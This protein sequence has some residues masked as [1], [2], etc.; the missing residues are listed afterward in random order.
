[1]CT[2]ARLTVL[3]QGLMFLTFAWLF[4]ENTN[5]ALERPYSTQSLTA[6][7]CEEDFGY[8]NISLGDIQSGTRKPYSEQ[9]QKYILNANKTCLA[10]SEVILLIIVKSAV[11]NFKK[12]RIVRETW[13]KDAAK[14]GYR[15]VFLLGYS[16]NYDIFINYE[17]T[18]FDDLI[19]YNFDD[20]YENNT[21]KLKMA[22]IWI[23]K[24]CSQAKYIAL[25]DD[26]MY[27]NIP[28]TIGFIKRAGK[29]EYLYSGFLIDKPRPIRNPSSKHYIPESRYP[30]DCFP[31]YIAG[32]SIFLNQHTVEMFVRVMPF[33]PEIPFDDVYVGFLAQKLRIKPSKTTLVRLDG[34]SFYPQNVSDIKY[35]LTKHGYENDLMFRI[36]HI[37]TLLST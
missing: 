4:L 15:L 14:R 23:L 33:V 6:Y 27:V 25:V 3:L 11:G 12:R 21:T 17:N 1:M 35:I 18:I 13:G 36:A 30:F 32:A 26:D 2:K 5:I 7:T 29:D 34:F 20:T 31:P 22:L 24:F 19:Q 9:S 8:S 16:A 10:R 28:N 37:E